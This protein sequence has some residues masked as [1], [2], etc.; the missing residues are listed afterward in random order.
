MAAKYT[1]WPSN[2]P[3][4]RKIGRPN[5]HKTCLHPPLQGL[6]KFTQI[7]IF[8]RKIYHLA[9]LVPMVTRARVRPLGCAHTFPRVGFPGRIQKFVRLRAG[10]PDF[11][12]YNI[13]KRKYTK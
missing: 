12:W 1:K 7:P 10:L 11:S 6:Q 13:P 8:G 3:N 4:G 9:T 5:G 2:I